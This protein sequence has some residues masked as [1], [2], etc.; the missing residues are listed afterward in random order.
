M[1]KIIRSNS[2]G[3]KAAIVFIVI[4]IL[5]ICLAFFGIAYASAHSTRSLKGITINN[6]QDV[7]DQTPEQINESIQAYQYALD[8]RPY[9][10]RFQDSQVN[11]HG[12]DIG[13]KVDSKA[14][15][16]AFDFGKDGNIF[17][18][19]V[20]AIK[21]FLGAK[22]NIDVDVSYSEAMLNE[23]V[24]ALLENSKA[25]KEDSKYEINEDEIKIYKGHD[26]VNTNYTALY[27][28][29]QSDLLNTDDALDIEL[30][31]EVDESV[32]VDI[33][34]LYNMIYVEKQDA[35]YTKGG[36]YKPEKVGIS[37]DKVKVLSEYRSLKADEVMTVKL[38]KTEPT[39]T[40]K[41]LDTVLFSDVLGS[42]K[43]NYN[44][45]NKNRSTN[46]ALAA[47]SIN[48]KIYTPGEEFSY[49][50]EL[51]ERTSARGYKEAH[52]YTSSGVEDG[53][54]G[55][56][57]QISSTLYNAVLIAD[58][59]VTERRNHMYY[60]QYVKASFDATV[61]WGSIDFKFKN[62]RETPI[63]IVASAQNGVASVTIY[64]K[65]TENDYAI[66]LES[67]ILN[68]Y[69]YTTI[70]TDDPNLQFGKEVETQA[71]V[72]GYKSEGYKIYKDASGKEVKRVKIS[73][74][75]YRATNRHVTVGAKKTEVTP[76]T[77]P[78]VVEEPQ[79]PVVEEPTTTTTTT[80][81]T[82]EPVAETPVT[83]PA[84]EPSTTPSKPSGGTN[85]PTGWDTPENPNYRG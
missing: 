19:G 79:P 50:K 63:K 40:T 80:P 36:G 57:C 43:T 61:A 65:K 35:E 30:T 75:E 16:Q 52:I 4:A 15:T 1:S 62:N 46:L 14:A 29:I 7:G 47:N 12:S 59:E 6:V 67:K 38:V 77:P 33:E 58:L 39:V 49:N 54:G 23:Q 83:P 69:K 41:N 18:R 72:N 10:I 84:E 78:V 74:D 64:G 34:A 25:T 11:F 56:I 9:I 8:N 32:D 26:G 76:V 42:F 37:F 22:N 27:N 2:S 55:G 13:V 44:A 51:G 24:N 48:G 20:I 68:T 31:A 45:G 28:K 3:K 85:W 53:L 66:S 17:N 71:G 60:P 73:T 5:I 70:K 82:P 21:S 81:T